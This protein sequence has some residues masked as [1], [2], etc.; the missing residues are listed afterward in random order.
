[1]ALTVISF[2]A[3][4]HFR[5]INMNPTT[6][7]MRTLLGFGLRN[8]IQKIGLDF[9]GPLV[10]DFPPLQRNRPVQYMVVPSVANTGD[11]VY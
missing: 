7:K 6:R 5:S 3:A 4:F 1:M 9:A 10:P 11:T 2:I 8:A